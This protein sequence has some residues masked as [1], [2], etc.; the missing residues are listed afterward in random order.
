MDEHR[1]REAWL[2][3]L[4]SGTSGGLLALLL[5]LVPGVLLVATGAGELL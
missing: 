5:S 4:A 2:A 3:W 1:S